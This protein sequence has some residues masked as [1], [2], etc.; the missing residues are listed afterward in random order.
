MG[1]VA[2]AMPSS[3]A[4]SAGIFFPLVKSVAKASGSDPEIGTEKKTG[5][6]LIQSVFQATGNS[7]S[8]WLYGSAL[9]L[10]APRLAT[11]VGYNIPLSFASWVTAMGVP[12]LIAMFFTPLVTFWALP[13][14][15]KKT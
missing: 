8:L 14:E 4:R 9:N 7:S 3:T 6:F 11:Q 1:A 10:L 13:P 12:A 5:A 15:A 2:A